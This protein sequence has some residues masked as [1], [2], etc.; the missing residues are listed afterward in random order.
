[1]AIAYASEALQVV[2]ALLVTWVLYITAFALMQ[3]N[4]VVKDYT[5]PIDAPIIKGYVMTRSFTNKQFNTYNPLASNYIELPKSVNKLGGSQFSYTVWLRLDD[6]SQTNLG[7]KVIFL[8]G[9]ANLYEMTKEVNGERQALVDFAIKCPL[10]KFAPNGKDIIIEVNTTQNITERAIMPTVRTPDEPMRHNVFS[11]I[12]MKFVMWTL[13]FE[14][15]VLH[16]H[17]HESGTV[18]RFYVNDFL[19]YTKRFK[20]TLRLNN[21]LLHILPLIGNDK[22]IE[23]GYLADMTYY[24]RALTTLEIRR[25]MAQGV[26]KERY[27]DMGGNAPFNEPL[28]I[29]EY[30]KLDIYNW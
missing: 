13:V 3:K 16:G 20:G 9:D 24:N 22:P 10:V 5:K 21:G 4:E 30:N 12:P 2:L 18:F 27:D 15:D 1:M 25:I 28:Y 8:H 26:R 11:L 14:D 29:T 23:N 6:V 17:S 19:Y 7:G